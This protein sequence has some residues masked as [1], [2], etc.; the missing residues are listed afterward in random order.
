MRPVGFDW[1][2]LDCSLDQCLNDFSVCDGPD[3]AVEIVHQRL[4]GQAEA[5]VHGGLNVDGINRILAWIGGMRVRTAVDLPTAKAAAV[6]TTA[7]SRLRIWPMLTAK[8]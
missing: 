7:K 6:A 1:C 4:G 2:V 8:Y 3:A 5:V